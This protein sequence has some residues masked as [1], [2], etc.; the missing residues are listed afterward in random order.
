M[1]FKKIAGLFTCALIIVSASFAMAGVPDLQKSQAATAYA[2]PL[3]PVLFNLPNG[4]G[5]AFTAAAT[6]DGVTPGLGTA[7]VDAT[8]TV[9]LIDGG[10]V[11][12]ANFPREDL[13]LESQDGGMAFC[14]GGTNA[15]GETDVTGTTTFTFPLAAG[16]AS[17]A[18]TLVMVN[19]AALTSNSGLPLSFNSADISS[20]G[21]VNLSDV[22]LFAGDFFGGLNPFRSDLKYDGVV[23]LSDVV[24]LAQG[25]GAQCP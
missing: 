10:D 25:V 16:G 3:V 22:P 21:K 1:E 7:V 9:T 23:N 18:V 5:S 14:T 4:A 2:G 13:W 11:P 8:I 15:D 19:G 12:V 17:Q 6:W 20:D 24:R